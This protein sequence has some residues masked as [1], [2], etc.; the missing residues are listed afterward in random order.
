MIAQIFVRYVQGSWQ[1]IVSLQINFV[2]FVLIS[3]MHVQM[4]AK[5]MKLS[6]A[7]Y[8]RKFAGSALKLAAKWQLK[9]KHEQLACAFNIALFYPEYR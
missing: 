2:P 1:E 4:S 7:R 5:N 3:V 6:T 8:V 9:I